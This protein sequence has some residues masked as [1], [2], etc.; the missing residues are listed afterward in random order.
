MNAKP[1]DPGTD[2]GGPILI[3]GTGRSGT[4]LLVRTLDRHP[5][6][7]ALRWET[8]F[9]V[10]PP[11]LVHVVE[12]GGGEDALG[13]FVRRIKGRWYKRTLNPGKSN[14]YE[15]GLVSD[16]T[17]DE[18]ERA[19]AY[20]L[21]KLPE[22][23]TRAKRCRLAGRFVNRVF[24]GMMRRSGAARWCEKTPRNL[25]LMD[26]LLDLFPRMKLI[27]VLRDGRDVVAS[28]LERGFWPIAAGHEFPELS[29][30][31]GRLTFERATK[32]WVDVLEIARR[33]RPKLP[34]GT[35]LQIRLE[36]LVH[37]SEET[38]RTICRFIGEDLDPRMLDQDSSRAHVGRWRESFSPDQVRKFWSIAGPTMER[39]GYGSC[40]AK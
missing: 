40:E 34:E 24:G 8:Q 27:S 35:Y 15:A 33:I 14:E 39:E 26:Q 20:F 16:V 37:N 11:G 10:A 3:G 22:C 32:Y 17:W 38:L 25:L 9:I 1:K 21:E 19:L 29:A 13:E 31:H 5:R 4:T 36:D 2:R 30:Y 28:M 12:S 23:D 6:I 7:H 18:L